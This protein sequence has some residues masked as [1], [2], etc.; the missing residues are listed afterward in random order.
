MIACKPSGDCC[1]PL[2]VSDG[3]W[4]DVLDRCRCL[5]V[6]RLSAECGRRLDPCADHRLGEEH[7][8]PLALLGVL[9]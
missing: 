8:E 2:P 7:V 6:G 9:C 4:I 1:L 5:E 3:R